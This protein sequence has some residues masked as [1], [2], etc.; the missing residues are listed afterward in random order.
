L[1]EIDPKTANEVIKIPLLM[2]IFNL[3]EK[4]KFLAKEEYKN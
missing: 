1:K 2:K 3:L 4:K